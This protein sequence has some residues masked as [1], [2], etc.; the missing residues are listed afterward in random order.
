MYLLRIV[1]GN[2]RNF[3]DVVKTRLQRFE[4]IFCPD[5]VPE[6]IYSIPSKGTSFRSNL[7]AHLNYL[8][9]AMTLVCDHVYHILHKWMARAT[10]IVRRTTVMKISRSKTTDEP[11]SYLLPSRPEKRRACGRP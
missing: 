1:M 11:F 3:F 10:D 7:Y 4:R 6:E 2:L 5:E 8:V 9:I